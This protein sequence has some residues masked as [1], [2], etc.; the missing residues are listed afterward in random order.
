M[1]STS[2]S[3]SSYKNILKTTSLFASVKVVTILVNIVKNKIVAM[4]LGTSGVGLLG[5]FTTALNLINSVSDLGISK[6]SV[7]NVSV[8]VA[9]KDHQKVSKT[10]F[11]FNVFLFFLSVLSALLTFV[12]SRQLSFYSFGNYNYSGSFAWLSIAVLL[13]SISTGQLAILQGVRHLKSLAKASTFGAIVGLLVS[14]PLFYFL[15]EMSIVPSLITSAIVAIFFSF[16]FYKKIELVSVSITKTEFKKDGKDMVKLGIAMMLVSFLV[17]FSGFILRSYINQTSGVDNVGIFQ[18]GFTIVSG[19]FGMIFT[20]MST[21]YFPRLSAINENNVKIESEV[22]Q[23]SIIALILLGPLVVLLLFVMPMVIEILYS[24]KFNEACNYVNWAIF[25]VV[26]QA[27]GQTMGMILLAKNR[28]NIF[29]SFVLVFQIIFLGISVCFF[30]EF[31][32]KG[33]GIAYSINMFLYML[34]LQFVV[35]YLYNIKFSTKF[36]KIL[37]SILTITTLSFFSKDIEILIIRYAIGLLLII[38]SLLY[39]VKM[40]KDVLE[41]P[42]IISLI[43]NKINQHRK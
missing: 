6:S 5:I 41:I 10:I 28:S 8:A 30:N 33:L 9:T 12:F 2:D 32:M 16:L 18:A 19:Y 37:V 40:L 42:S 7:R 26:F 20:A 3:Q 11:V 39:S 27:V 35:K 31:G 34:V 36:Y 29:V 38:V 22:N 21:D 23:Q 43:K 4:L 13:N 25:G 17:A 15:G 1:E 24:S 14:V